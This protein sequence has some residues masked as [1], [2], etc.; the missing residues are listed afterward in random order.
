[1][2]MAEIDASDGVSCYGGADGFISISVSGGTSS[3]DFEWIGPIGFSADTEDISN[4]SAGTYSVTVTDANG[5][6]DEISGIEIDEPAELVAEVDLITGA[7][8]S[9]TLTGAIDISV[10]GG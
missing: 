10:S 1:E 3:Y 2:L 8:C 5:C 7:S 9:G 4:L 6:I